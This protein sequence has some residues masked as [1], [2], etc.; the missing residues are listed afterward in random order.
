[1]KKTILFGLLISIFSVGSLASAQMMSQTSVAYPSYACP[2]FSFNLYRGLHDYYTQG[3]VTAL[4]QFLSSRYGNQ[5]VTGYFGP[6]TYAN[7]V[8]F[9]QE[10]GIY[11]TTGGVGPLT[12]AAIA[13][14]CGGV[15]SGGAV[16]ITSVSGPN[17]LAVNQQGTWAI[18]TNAPYGTNVS[19]SV[20]WGDEMYYGY[21]YAGA[22]SLI[23]QQNTFTH[24]YD[25][26]GTYIIT[27]TATDSSGRTSTATASVV[28]GGAVA[29][30]PRITAISPSQGPIGTR[31]VIEG[32]NF[33]NDNKVHFDTGGAVHVSSFNSGT[34]YF[35]IPSSVGPCDWVGDTS[36]VRCLAA[37]RLVTPGT[38]AIKVSN[39]NGE[40]NT[41]YFTVTDTNTAA[42]FTA[43]PTLGSAP[44]TVNFAINSIPSDTDMASV[45]ID[46]G[47]GD[48]AK[49]QTIYCFRAPCIP[50][51]TSS[52]IYKAA[53]TY[54]AKLMRD[55][56]YCAPGMYCTMMYREPIILASV[57]IT[58][59]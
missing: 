19:V 57:T 24:T 23:S 49:P 5:L 22:S 17:A 35:T 10:Q 51:M 29:N 15:V 25:R 37:S 45:Y 42:S 18:S 32:S 8:R 38:Y 43:S 39:V 11:P 55:Y 27:F 36:P 16:Q 59:R 41:V 58:V 14:L 54:T 7:V 20:R 50:A 52:H 34:L 31:V 4:Q 30:A 46:F 44:L 2:T 48:S 9:Q 26:A 13:R 21:A 28:V 12:R 47:D 53:G 40:S 33:T 1:M 56:N 6:M 3:Q